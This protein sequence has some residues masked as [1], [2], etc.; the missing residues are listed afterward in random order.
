MVSNRE[1]D[2]VKVTWIVL[3]VAACIL[4]IWLGSSSPVH[5]GLSEADDAE[6]AKKMTYFRDRHGICYAAIASVA[7]WP[8]ATVSIATVPCE[9]VGL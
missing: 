2:P 3:A 6:L 1:S 5:T 7:Y 4:L 9:K 8:L